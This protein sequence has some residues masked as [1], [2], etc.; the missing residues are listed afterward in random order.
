ML[1]SR[2]AP[3]G[4]EDVRKGEVFTI[5][6]NPYA[7]MIAAFEALN[8]RMKAQKNTTLEMKDV[9]LDHGAKFD[10]LTKDA[11][12]SKVATRNISSVY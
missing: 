4:L 11:L 2:E 5:A 6:S 8:D 1:H 7:A 10:I 12:N 9:L 3:K